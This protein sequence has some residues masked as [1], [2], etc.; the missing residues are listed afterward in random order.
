MTFRA[1]ALLLL[2]LPACSVFE[3]SST[4]DDALTITPEGPGGD[5][6]L[7]VVVPQKLNEPTAQLGESE[8]TAKYLKYFYGNTEIVPGVATRVRPQLDAEGYSTLRITYAYGNA[9]PLSSRGDTLEYSDRFLVRAGETKTLTLGAI[10]VVGRLPQP[11]QLALAPFD[12]TE[13]LSYVFSENRYPRWSPIGRL[14]TN[15]TW[16]WT[17]KGPFL[18][19][20]AG[21]YEW[22]RGKVGSLLSFDVAEG[23][24]TTVDTAVADPF[25]RVTVVNSTDA[26]FPD[27]RSLRVRV[28]CVREGEGKEWAVAEDVAASGVVTSYQTTKAECFWQTGAAAARFELDVKGSVTLQKRRLDVDDVLI[29]D[30]PSGT[31]VPGSYTVSQKLDGETRPIGT[32]GTKTGLDLVPG[33]YHLSIEYTSPR[34]N[35]QR[36]ER[37]VTLD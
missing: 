29:T 24:V 32:F 23:A 30:E 2:A 8:P 18:P 13:S 16:I 27:A 28:M 14:S 9:H 4:S 36:V 6:T 25:S 31:K 15:A 17:A 34:G 3:G 26:A 35:P 21:H 37:D 10:N 33:T 12:P 19:A 20:F 7:T 5:I 1:S 22:S 11:P